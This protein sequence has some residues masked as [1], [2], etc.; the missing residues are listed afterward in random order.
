MRHGRANG[1]SVILN[2]RKSPATLNR[3]HQAISTV[4]TWAVDQDWISKNT[5]LGIKRQKEPRGRVR[6]LSDDERQ[7]LL[8]A[9]DKSD[10]ADLGLLVR[11]ALST[12]ARRGELLKI[13][14]SDVDLKKG[15][16]HVGKTK[17][18]DRRVLPL[19][20]PVIALLR[21]KPRPIRDGLLFA[22]PR[23][24]QRPYYDCRK[25]WNAAIAEA[26]ISNFKFHDIRHTT[27]S[28]LAMSGASPIEIGDVLG[29]K[30][31]AMV[32][33]YSHLATDHKTKLT[34]LV[35]TDIV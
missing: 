27:A 11:L 18:D 13:R 15:L 21:K 32:R 17:N 6:W 16:A 9:C 12:G 5:A 20:K 25:F 28:Y 33:R 26:G 2:R 31:L 23:D 8:D 4:L 7:R 22:S 3:Y 14:W 19:I 1:I 24:P 10:W 29:H 35:F 30:T 34:E